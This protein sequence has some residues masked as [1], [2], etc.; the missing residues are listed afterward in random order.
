[1]KRVS[2]LFALVAAAVVVS[3]CSGLFAP[4]RV[5]DN[6]IL[7]IGD[8]MGDAQMEAASYYATGTPDGLFIQN[9]S[10]ASTVTTY[11]A[12]SSVTDSAAAAT[13][14]ATGHKV[15]NGVISRDLSGS[16]RDITTILEMA[17][18]SG[19]AT[20]LVTTTYLTHATAAAFGA[21]VDTRT[22]YDGIA[23][24][25]LSGSRPNVLFGG[26]ENG[27]TAASLLAA[28]YSVAT[29]TVS[30]RALAASGDDYV[31][32]VIGDAHLPYVYDGRPI[33]VPTLLEMTEA[34]IE[35][36]S[37]D[38]DGFFLVV[39]AGRIDHAGHVHDIDRLIPEV[40]E[41]DAVVEYVVRHLGSSGTT[42]IIVT[43]DHETGGLVVTSPGGVGTIPGVTWTA[44]AHT[45]T[46]VSLFAT[47]PSGIAFSTV[48]DNTHVFYRMRWVL[49]L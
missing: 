15:A 35:V 47:G 20:G 48:T 46:P 49:D 26:G 16:G 8:G 27:L 36:V 22:D 37:R 38:P 28:G 13:A 23:R 14:M 11:S 40:L 39:E 42:D 7:F 30:M 45:G 4:R 25:Y 19:L 5:G 6:V 3:S 29:D 33:G 21:H 10:V 2:R 18:D 41:L 24:D 9:L 1:M 43:A 31:A 12:S 34:A 44:D 17:S 32:V